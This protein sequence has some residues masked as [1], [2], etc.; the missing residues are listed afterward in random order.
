[1]KNVY[2]HERS[3]HRLDEKECIELSWVDLKYFTCKQRL[4]QKSPS[5]KKNKKCVLYLFV[6]M[7]EE[8]FFY[9][10]LL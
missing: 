9:I 7:R 10:E 2:T 1:M 8:L 5:L 4:L 3:L 6:L